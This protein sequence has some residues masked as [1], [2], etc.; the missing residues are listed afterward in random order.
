MRL[1]TLI[2][3][4]IALSSSAW[5][6]VTPEAARWLELAL[7][8]QGGARVADAKVINWSWTAVWLE[9]GKA[10]GSSY[11]TQNLDF[12]NK[13]GWLESR[14]GRDLWRTNRFDGR[15]GQG[16]DW[17]TQDL[18][19]TAIKE[20]EWRDEQVNMTMFQF[21][22]RFGK[23]RDKAVVLGQRTLQGVKGTLLEVTTLGM[24]HQLLLRQDG[25]LLGEVEADG[26]QFL[27]YNFDNFVGVVLPRFVRVY[28]A[29]N[30][31]IE[32]QI[33]HSLTMLDRLPDSA[34]ELRPKAACHEDL[35]FWSYPS[36]LQSA[37]GL[38]IQLWPNSSL[39]IAGLKN[40]DEI[41]SV[42]GQV[43]T[44]LLTHEALAKLQAQSGKL[45]LGVLRDK[46]IIRLELDR[47]KP[48]C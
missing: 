38:R 11:S 24:K 14:L 25:L 46:K 43:L 20:T 44:G 39:G 35:D 5:A 17:N 22:L 41:R 2:I 28:N 31:L 33:L 42:N 23:N 18:L 32:L 6:Q 45:Q 40:G 37:K 15:G 21:G 36:Q 1:L 30:E 29:K 4:F 26:T 13:R 7:K 10:F 48:A 8:R 19:P 27:Y 3:G 12:V 16:W 47:P 34:F 9:K